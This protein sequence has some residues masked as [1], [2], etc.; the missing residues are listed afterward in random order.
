LS[1]SNLGVGENPLGRLPGGTSDFN[2]RSNTAMGGFGGYKGSQ[3]ANG[4]AGNNGYAV[5]YL[6]VPGVFVHND[7]GGW[8]ATEEIYVKV[9]DVWQLVNAIYIKRE[10]NWITVDGDGTT[11]FLPVEGFFGV[12]S[13]PAPASPVP[14]PSPGY[15]DGGGG[16]DG[17]TAD[18]PSPNADGS[19]G[20]ENQG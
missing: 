10:G 8:V 7:S 6:T 3:N 15:S 5:I 1:Y 12:V 16:W 14:P 2:Y 11:N 9:N 13:R 4:Q 19:F 17:P 18:A 20:S